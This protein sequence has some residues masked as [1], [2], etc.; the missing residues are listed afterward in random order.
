VQRRL[1]AAARAL[2]TVGRCVVWIAPGKTE[3]RTGSLIE[4]LI[5]ILRH[6]R[7][8]AHQVQA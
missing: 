5:P 3:H 2:G 4:R 6:P 7:Q 1:R 8:R